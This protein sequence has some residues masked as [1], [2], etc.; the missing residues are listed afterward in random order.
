VIVCDG[1]GNIQAVP[2]SDSPDDKLECTVD[3]CNNSVPNYEQKAP[4]T[5]CTQGGGAKCNQGGACVECIQNVDCGSN[6]CDPS[7]FKCAA[8]SCGDM[9]LNGSET[10][11]DCGGSECPGCGPGKSCA[12]ASD[13]V[14]DSCV[15]GKCQAS[16]TDGI[17]NAGETD[18]DCGGP[19]CAKCVIGKECASSSDCAS[20]NC[21]S[22]LCFIDHLVINEIDYDQVTT[23]TAEFVEIYN[24]TGA[25][26]N[27]A[28]LSLVFVNGADKTTYLSFDLSP[29][30]TLPAGQYLVVGTTQV[31]IPAGALKLNFAEASDTIQN[32]SPDGVA[33]VDNVAPKLIDALSYE[34]SM[35][36]LAVMGLPGL[37]KLVEGT[38][39]PAGQADSSAVDS[40][41]LI[42]LPDGTDTNNAASDWKVSGTPTPGAANKP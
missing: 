31:K 27:L 16:C 7:T 6:V 20:N 19:T 29:A 15:G 18:I 40:V 13:C 28:G 14:G 37:A 12:M 34:G 26:K 22:K 38:V 8:A 41:S 32:G 3:T 17:K 4:G 2:T 42:R 9:M 33:L 10:D 1:Q 36:P 39:L 5:A 24:G 25:A 23:D 11:I 35:P 21:V 30:G